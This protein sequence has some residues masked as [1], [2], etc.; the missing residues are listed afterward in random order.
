MIS[1]S[2]Y[3][4][5]SPS[6]TATRHSRL[7]SVYHLPAVP[8]VLPAQAK[9]YLALVYI[10]LLLL[11][12]LDNANSIKKALVKCKFPEHDMDLST[13]SRLSR[14]R[15]DDVDNNFALQ[16]QRH[17]STAAAISLLGIGAHLETNYIG[18]LAQYDSVLND[19]DNLE[20]L[21]AAA[22][23]PVLKC[24]LSS[25]PW[26]N[27]NPHHN[28]INTP[29]TSHT[30]VFLTPHFPQQ[31]Q[32]YID[33]P[34]GYDY[35]AYTTKQ[36]KQTDPQQSRS[37][38]YRGYSSSKSLDVTICHAPVLYAV[39]SPANSVSTSAYNILLHNPSCG[40]TCHCSYALNIE[41]RDKSATTLASL[42]VNCSEEDLC[43]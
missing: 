11:P 19:L 6:R 5:G 10:L 29:I 25:D 20:P 2:S 14:V 26:I 7:S 28:S 9:H 31:E 13:D 42:D 16:E 43:I 41:Q 32:S 4:D 38:D 12:C 15:N 39:E 22:A 23:V 36:G 21:S 35:Q 33:R 30:P 18:Y 27:T 3:K 37:P 8:I 1:S 17:S 24:P 34:L 40:Y